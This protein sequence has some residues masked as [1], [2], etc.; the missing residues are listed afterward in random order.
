MF[1]LN[2]TEPE[3]DRFPRLVRALQMANLCHYAIYQD[4][5]IG[6]DTGHVLLHLSPKTAF[7]KYTAFWQSTVIAQNTCHRHSIKV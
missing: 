4:M 6:I 7:V 2:V 1:V 3:A 5:N